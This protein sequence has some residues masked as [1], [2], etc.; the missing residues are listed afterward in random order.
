MTISNIGEREQFVWEWNS[1]K[2]MIPSTT[3]TQRNISNVE[4]WV[5][6]ALTDASF[7][8]PELTQAADHYHAEPS[9]LRPAIRHEHG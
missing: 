6:T 7:H 3:E 1:L 8:A 5:S 9:G 4:T 2:S